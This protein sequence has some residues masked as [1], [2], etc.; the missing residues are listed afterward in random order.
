[1]TEDI[2]YN[3]RISSKWTEALFLALM[4]IFLL[5]F[6]W[7]VTVTSLDILGV[8]LLCLSSIFLFYSLNYRILVIRLT[9][10]SL[11]LTFGI[12]TWKLPLDNV[13]DCRLDEIPLLMRMGGA[14]IHFMMIRQ[15]YR[16]SFNFLEYPRVVVAFKK[17]AGP[18]QDISFTTRQ[19][20][21]V[22]RLMREAV[23]ANRTA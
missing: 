1:M 19:P 5:L 22:L 7:H 12:F 23:S 17:K 8:V 3:E 18:V 10:Q 2:L 6:V 21:E 13:A 9:P 20:D 15:R 16:A 4:I 14:G 11:K